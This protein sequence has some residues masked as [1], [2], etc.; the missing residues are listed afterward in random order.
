MKRQ[1]IEQ[2]IQHK[3]ARLFSIKGRMPL[4]QSEVF[5]AY[6]AEKMGWLA[7]VKERLT[8][9]RMDDYTQGYLQ[10]MVECLEDDAMG[11]EQVSEKVRILSEEIRDLRKALSDRDDRVFRAPPPGGD[12][13][14]APPGVSRKSSPA[15]PGGML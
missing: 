13:R 9:Q 4:L 10:G 7:F 14:E 15:I 5:Q 2:E 1:A 8:T 11:A 6:R 3:E 12:Y